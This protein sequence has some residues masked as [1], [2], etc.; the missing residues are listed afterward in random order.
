MSTRRA[1]TLAEVLIACGIFMTLSVAM[2]GILAAAGTI[3]Q[4]GSQ[5]RAANDEAMAVIGRIDADL[6]RAVP[7]AQGGRFYARVDNPATGSCVVGWTIDIGRGQLDASRRATTRF[8]LYGLDDH[9]RLLRREFNSF[10]D[11]NRYNP[12][13]Q[14]D[15]DNLD[16]DDLPTLRDSSSIP[17]EIITTGCLHFGAWVVGLPATDDGSAPSMT[18]PLAQVPIHGR[19]WTT[20]WD[21]DYREVWTPPY[22]EV[23]HHLGG[24]Q[25][26]YPEA[27]RLT[28]ILTGDGRRRPSGRLMRNCSPDDMILH[29]GGIGALPTAPGSI[30]RIGPPDRSELIGYRSY[31]DGRVYV[32]NDDWGRGPLNPYD[33]TPTGR[34]IYRS[35]AR[36]HERGAEVTFGR[37]YTITRAIGQ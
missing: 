30:L 27:L 13:G 1:M 24:G 8:V 29:V 37:I 33:T 9:E 21:S 19:F 32:N 10:D 20:S 25:W 3:Y 34:G 2:V 17:G 23:G 35:L 11:V 4:A 15:Y 16:D 18:S 28:L 22:F 7:A 5:G 14:Y 31:R 6:A 26:P 12:L 36:D